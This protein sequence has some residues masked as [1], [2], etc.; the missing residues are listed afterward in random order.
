MF[1]LPHPAM[2]PI[3][4]MNWLIIKG[5][6]FIFTNRR[7]APASWTFVVFCWA[8]NSPSLSRPKDPLW[9]C[10]SFGSCVHSFGSGRQVQLHG[11][12]LP[13]YE[14]GKHGVHRLVGLARSTWT[15]ANPCRCLACTS[16]QSGGVFPVYKA[17]A[18]RQG[19][20]GEKGLLANWDP[21]LLWHNSWQHCSDTAKLRICGWK[22]SWHKG[23]LHPGII[24]N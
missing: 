7:C 2:I 24:R 23:K 9:L 19:A 21:V 22:K 10:L 6:H 5:L 12:S 11:L 4:H 14:R 17:N 16:W 3:L 13:E 18:S 1:P 15:S 20:T 8:V